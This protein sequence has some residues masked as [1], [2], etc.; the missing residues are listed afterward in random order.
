MVHQ[1]PCDYPRGMCMPITYKGVIEYGR[2]NTM[3][4]RI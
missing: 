1:L 3:Q 4:A 2:G